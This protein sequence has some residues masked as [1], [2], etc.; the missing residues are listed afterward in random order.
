MN[1]LI[2]EDNQIEYNELIKLPIRDYVLRV[3]SFVNKSVRL[4]EHA[5]KMK[6]KKR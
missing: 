3:K 4:K 1:M 6:R 5:D 2:V